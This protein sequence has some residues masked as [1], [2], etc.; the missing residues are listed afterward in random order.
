MKLSAGLFCLLFSL[1]LFAQSDYPTLFSQYKL[2]QFEIQSLKLD[3]N[4]SG[5]L[6]NRGSNYNTDEYSDR[7]QNNDYSLQTTVNYGFLRQSDDTYLRISPALNLSVENSQMSAASSNKF[8]ESDNWYKQRDNRLIGSVDLFIDNATYFD[9]NDHFYGIQNSSVFS[10]NQ[11][12]SD[13]KNS[14]GNLSDEF[15]M[16]NSFH[17]DLTIYLG[18]GRL[19]VI[20][21]L[22]QAI[23]LND[24][25]KQTGAILSNLDDQKLLTLAQ[26]LQ[27]SNF[28][29]QVHALSYKYLKSA[30][31]AQLGEIVGSKLSSF[32]EEYVMDALREPRITRYEGFLILGG[33][34]SGYYSTFYRTSNLTNKASSKTETFLIGPKV[35]ITAAG[36]LNLETGWYISAETSAGF[37]LS[38]LDPYNQQ[39]RSKASGQLLYE[40]TDRV[41]V[42]ADDILSYTHT[43]MAPLSYQEKSYAFSNL[44]ALSGRYFIEDQFTVT[45]SLSYLTQHGS[46]RFQYLNLNSHFQDDI[47]VNFGFSYLFFNDSQFAFL[48][49]TGL[50]P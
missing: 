40:L 21:P 3:G 39:Y 50:L 37:S 22:I 33:I 20:T 25:L 19:R 29:G 42:S 4:F 47:R 41:I 14:S 48:P 31:D 38:H 13:F 46:N 28:Y 44:A 35:K 11:M 17:S 27:E 2:N 36:S 6:F 12:G 49:D 34:Q 15:Q 1:P 43:N 18:S 8:S 10:S 9:S 32:Q 23:R 45:A 24:R 7:Y 30:I 26:L 16:A 5:L